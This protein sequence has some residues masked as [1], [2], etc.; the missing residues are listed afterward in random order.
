[1]GGIA[2]FSTLSI[3]NAGTGYTLAASATGLAGATSSTFNITSGPPPPGPVNIV[4]NGGF[5]TGTAPWKHYHNGGA[6]NSFSVVTTAPVPEGTYQAKIVIDATIGTNNQLYQSGLSLEAGRAYRLSLAYRASGAT[7]FR[8]RLIESDDDY[9]VYGFAF[10]TLSASTWLSTFSFDFTASGFTG[11]ATDAML[12]FYFVN[13]TPSRTI[14]LDN[15]VISKT[16]G[17]AKQGVE[18]VP[19]PTE[20]ALMQNY[21]NPFNPSTTIRYALPEAVMVKLAVYN[22]VGQQ[23]AILVEEAQEAGYHDARFEGSHLSSGVYFYRIQ[24]GDFVA[25][26]RFVLLK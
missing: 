8:V 1:V 13:G 6:T 17:L 14:Y 20:F 18:P 16:P 5:E 12:Q 3:N 23:V 25:T 7:T 11:T 4:V 22:S 24:A 19:L 26:R 9:T 10:Q 2:T 15:I 21:P